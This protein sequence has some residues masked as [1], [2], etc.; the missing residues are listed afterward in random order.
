MLQPASSFRLSFLHC[1]KGLPNFSFQAGKFHCQH[2]PARMQ[3]NIQR[4]KNL[5]Q[6]FLHRG[7][8][9]PPDSVAFHCSTQDLPDCE[10]YSRSG[11]VIAPAVKHRD[12]SRKMF[13]AFFVDRLKI[14]MPEQSG[15]LGKLLQRLGLISV[16]GLPDP[17]V[18]AARS[19]HGNQVSLK[20]AC[21]LWPDGATAQPDHPSFSFSCE[22]HASWND[23]C[24]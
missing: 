2:T 14:C 12:V 4:Q 15:T 1:R 11:A 16:H 18:E 13:P 19:I 5:T 23:A 8:H 24:G 17:A 20:P 9:P 7:P 21:V 10:S 22:N 3:H 6:M